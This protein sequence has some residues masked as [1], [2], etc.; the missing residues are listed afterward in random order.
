MTVN[1][2]TFVVNGGGT[3]GN[4]SG[5][6]GTISVYVGGHQQH[7]RDIGQFDPAGGILH[8]QRLLGQTVVYIS[9]TTVTLSGNANAAVSAATGEAFASTAT[10]NAAHTIVLDN[11]ASNVNNRLGGRGLTLAGG[12]LTM[13]PSTTAAVAETVA[14]LTLLPGQSVITLSANSGYPT[15]FT[16]DFLTTRPLHGA[17]RP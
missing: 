16:A 11:G 6:A 8:R 15:N 1:A 14:A 17:T 7:F 9:G 10:I 2:G 13:V 3:L 12:A 4:V 5:S